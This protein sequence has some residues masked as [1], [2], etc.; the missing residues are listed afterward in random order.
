[1]ALPVG[2][3]APDFTVKT[4]TADGPVDFKLSDHIGSQN[5]VLLFFP[6]AFTHVC[7]AEMC[8]MSEETSK[9][10]GLNALVCGVSV[11]TFYSQD[12]WA[13]QE[14]ITIP[15]LSDFKHEV[16][17]AYDVVWPNFSGMGPSSARA[18]FVINKE[19]V[20]VYSEQCP[21]LLDLPDFE[22]IER[23]LSE[24]P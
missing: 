24:L 7:K 8:R 12:A 1:M 6:G 22:A 21:S 23:V 10:D 9:Y 11:D 17:Q 16:T 20:I 3:K 2:S 15:L 18:A 4:M 5:I 19:G 14:K 13:K